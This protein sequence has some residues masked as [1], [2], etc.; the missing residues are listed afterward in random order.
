MSQDNQIE[1]VGLAR[2]TTDARPWFGEL[3]SWPYDLPRIGASIGTLAELKKRQVGFSGTGRLGGEVFRRGERDVSRPLGLT[4]GHVLSGSGG[5]AG[6]T[7]YQPRVTSDRGSVRLVAGALN[8]IGTIENPGFVGPYLYAYPGEAARHY[9]VDCA[10]LRLN[11]PAAGGTAVM[12]ARAHPLDIAPPRRLKVRLSGLHS[13]A[14]GVVVDTA[15]NV[16][17]AAW[18]NVPE[19]P[20]HRKP[21]RSASFRAS[22]RFRQPSRRRA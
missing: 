11:R 9:H 12:S 20:D 5:R 7:V 14:A 21:A 13:R 10:V 4:C 18:T 6:E 1:V 22:R 3:S 17:V 19:Q 2:D 15:A 16:P 8:P